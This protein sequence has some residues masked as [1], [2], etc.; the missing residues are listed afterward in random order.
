MSKQRTTAA[1]RRKGEGGID[2]HHITGPCP[3][4]VDGVRPGHKCTRPYRARVWATTGQ[5]GRKRVTVYG[6]TEAEVLRK[7]RSLHAAEAK[8]EVVASTTTVKDWMSTADDATGWWAIAAP[9]L[10]ANTR[11]GYAS[12]INTYIIPH[13][14]HRKLTTLQPEHVR[15]M[16]DAMRKQGLSGGTCLGVHAILRRALKVAVREGKAA[17]NVCDSNVMDAPT[18]KRVARKPLTVEDA[19][20]VLRCAGDNPRPWVALLTGLRQ[21]EALALRWHDLHLLDGEGLCSTCGD[22][23]ADSDGTPAP[24]LVVAEAVS[25]ETGKGLVYDNPKSATSTNRVVPLVTPVAARLAVARAKALANGATAEGFVFT[26]PRGGPV[27]AQQDWSAWTALLDLAGVEHVSLHGARHTTA[28]L[29]EDAGVADRVVAEILGHSTV[30]VTHGYQ[31]GN[32]PAKQQ[33]M[34]A[35]EAHL[36]SKDTQAVA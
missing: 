16:Y 10:K 30:Q 13:L 9:T 24:F 19:W 34:R 31:Q 28:H 35:L 23:H 20:K 25:R 3:A 4:P 11:K 32:L 18:A 14:G 1:R 36:A 8:G 15:G 6:K 17:R 12:K 26:A 7:V 22:V 27:Y 21:G 2:R 5:G 33:A 29:L